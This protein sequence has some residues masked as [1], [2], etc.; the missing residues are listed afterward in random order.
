MDVDYA[1][2][3][4]VLDQE[5]F[6]TLADVPQ[7]TSFFFIE[8]PEYDASLLL[9]KGLDAERAVPAMEAVLAALDE[10]ADWTPEA[11]LRTL[12][13]VVTRLGFI[14]TKSDGTQVPDRGPVFMMVRVGVSGRK[15]TPGLTEMMTV[16][17]RER[18]LLRLRVALEKR[19]AL[20]G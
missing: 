12:D 17:G 14:R 11:L 10:Q 18:T 1:R 2:Q 5:R 6:K 7:L 4:F 13:G 8:Q 16:L 19:R 15:E 3:V 20:A 9:G